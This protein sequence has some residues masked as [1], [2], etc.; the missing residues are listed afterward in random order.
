[1]DPEPFRFHGGSLLRTERSGLGVEVDEAA[2]RAADAR[3][4]AWRNPVRRHED[5]SFAEW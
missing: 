3:G 1:M 2:V 5:G 4:H